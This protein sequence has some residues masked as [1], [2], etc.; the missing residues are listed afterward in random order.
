MIDASS[1]S[2][3]DNIAETKKVVEY[4]H[5]RNVTVEA[6]LGEMCFGNGDRRPWA[7]TDPIS[8][9]ENTREWILPGSLQKE[10]SLGKTLKTRFGHLA[11]RTLR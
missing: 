7:T 3:E 10:C 2:F 4:A 8:Q 1:L 11:S 6:E 9:L 5:A